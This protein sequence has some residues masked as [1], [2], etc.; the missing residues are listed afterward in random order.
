MHNV[1]QAIEH[2]KSG[3][4]IVLIDEECRDNEGDLVL[5]AEF[6]TGEHINFMAT[7]ACGLVQ[8][9]LHQTIAKRLSLRPMASDN[10]DQLGK[11]FTVSI[12]ARVGVTTGISAFDRA[13]TIQV[14]VAPESTSA[15]LV[16]PGHIF[17][18]VAASGGVLSRKG[19]IEGS[20][21]LMTIAGLRPAAVIC[22]IMRDDGEMARQ[23]DLLAFAEKYGLP[24]LTIAE[25]A[26]FRMVTETLVDEV[27]VARLPSVYAGAVL[28]ARAFRSRIDGREFLAVV[29]TP[30][31]GVPI[32]RIHSECLTGDVFGSLR[33]DCGPQLRTALQLVGDSEGGAVIY[34]TGHEGRGIGLVNKIRAYALQ[35]RGLDTVEANAALGFRDDAREYGLAAQILKALGMT[36]VRLL[37]NNPGKAAALRRYAIAVEEEVPLCPPVNAYNAGYLATKR[38]KLGHRLSP[39]PA[40][41]HARDRAVTELINERR[42]E[43]LPTC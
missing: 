43:R 16:S 21:D 12:E 26:D 23:A 40:R 34:M 22:Q 18:L 8:L 10:H 13:R 1:A 28:E 7:H 17:P 42:S 38:D 2:L 14:A 30:R 35:D 20:V 37:S 3:R 32:V 9:A 25:I 29:K 39:I 15:D 6:V 4:P 33:C 19:N 24:M 36:T 31:T 11:P 5:P 41:P 27:A